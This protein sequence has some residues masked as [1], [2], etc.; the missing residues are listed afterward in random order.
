MPLFRTNPDPLSQRARSLKRRIGELESQIQELTSEL[1]AARSAEAAPAS[2]ESR[3]GRGG[4]VAAVQEPIFENIPHRPHDAAAAL[5]QAREA[6]AL[7]LKRPGLKTWWSRV[8]RRLLGVPPAEDKL[9]QY[10]AAGGLQGLRPLR[11]ERRVARNRIIFLSVVLAVI[12]WGLLIVFWK[13]N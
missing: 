5:G 12:L 3:S 6:V 8:R 13:T 10:L 11:Y 1:E 2:T 7:G 4:R 9:V